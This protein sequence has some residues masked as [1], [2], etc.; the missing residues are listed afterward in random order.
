MSFVLEAR[1]IGKRFAGVVALDDV[2][3]GVRPGSVHA[4]VGEN[5]AGKSTLMKILSGVYQPDAGELLRDG[6]PASFPS[7]RAA[8]AAG[9]AIIH[10]ELNLCPNLSVTD[11]L[12]MGREIVRRNGTVDARTERRLATEVLARL[13]EPIDPDTDVAD[14][15][16]GQQQVVEIARA[17][18]LQAR[19][20]IMDEPT[21]ALSSAEV[22]VLF[23][24]IREL[25]ASGVAIVYISHHLEEA[26]HHLASQVRASSA[27]RRTET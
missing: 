20:L 15:R 25:T 21:S 24:V 17:I 26:L 4:V 5:G 8:E 16:L 18:S 12:F 1:G 22:D 19:V 7:P 2:S 14:L 3:I 6:R 9:V 27:A 11:N 23:R 13:E 10:Q